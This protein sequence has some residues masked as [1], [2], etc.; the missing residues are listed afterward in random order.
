MF[1]ILNA[2][3]SNWQS[4]LGSRQPMNLQTI[5]LFFLEQQVIVWSELIHATA[6]TSLYLNARI[7]DCIY[8]TLHSIK[9]FLECFRLEYFHRVESTQKSIRT[10][11]SQFIANI[12]MS[13]TGIEIS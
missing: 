4:Q 7:E 13:Y 12:A 8:S 6:K 11:S 5:F 2:E 3:P 10:L 1:L 9:K